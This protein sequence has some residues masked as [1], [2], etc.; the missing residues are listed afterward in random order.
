MI[1]MSPSSIPSIMRTEGSNLCRIT[2]F[3]YFL[4]RL[5][6]STLPLIS[7]MFSL[8]LK[9]I[10]A[11]ETRATFSYVFPLE[12][13]LSVATSL[14]LTFMVSV[15]T[16]LGTFFRPPGLREL[17]ALRLLLALRSRLGLRWS[18]HTDL[19]LSSDAERRSPLPPPPPPLAPPPAPP[20]TATS[21][22]EPPSFKPHSLDAKLTKSAFSMQPTSLTPSAASNLRIFAALSA[23]SSSSVLGRSIPQPHRH[24]RPH[25]RGSPRPSAGGAAGR[26]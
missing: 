5:R 13:T 12:P 19:T 26:P 18:V 7:S 21:S 10:S 22:A 25:P 17:E 4:A 1:V 9:A 15:D 23:R 16:S 3:A 2:R 20:L 14:A 24:R 6:C 8:S 11:P